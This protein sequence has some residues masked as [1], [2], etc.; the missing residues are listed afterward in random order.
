MVFER[1]R[2]EE[3]MKCP[4]CKSSIQT[5]WETD[6]YCPECGAKF[7]D[8]FK[9]QIRLNLDTPVEGMEGRAVPKGL[10]VDVQKGADGTMLHDLK[11]R[12]EEEYKNVLRGALSD[13]RINLNEIL[14]LARKK[15]ELN[16]D[17]KEAIRLQMEVAGE[18]GLTV[19]EESDPNVND[20]VMEIDENK[21]YWAGEGDFIDFRITNISD[22]L[23]DNVFVMGR[24]KHL[25]SDAKDDPKKLP[26][27]QNKIFH[28]R[29]MRLYSGIEVAHISV[30]YLDPKGNPSVYETEL[31]FRVIEKGMEKREGDKSINI[32]ITAEKIMGNDLSSLAEM[33]GRD[34][35]KEEGS[36][37][38]SFYNES[39]KVWR[40]LP[41]F[42]DEEKT[43]E[44]RNQIFIQKRFKEGED[45]YHK[46]LTLKERAY[47]FHSKDPKN[48]KK[49]L[50]NSV[51][52]LEAAKACFEKVLD[53]DPEHEGS[54][55]KAKDIEGVISELEKRIGVLR[56]REK[57]PSINLTSALLT[58]GN[59]QKYIYLYSKETIT[60]GRLSTNDMILRVL[61]CLPEE[62][63]PENYRK[64]LQISGLHA[65]IF[66][67][68]TG[69]VFI[70]DR[71]KENKG[72]KNGTFLDRKRLA[73]PLYGYPLTDK[74]K[75]DIAGALGLECNFIYNDKKGKT[76]RDR[77]DSC[78]TVLGSVSKS[79][80][81]IDVKG[82]VNAIKIVRTSN[83]S[84]GEEY[85]ILIRK[86]TIGRSLY[87][88]IIIDG[89]RVSD[90]H[91]Q[92]FY[93]DGH[94]W[95]EDLNSRH[96]TWVNAEKIESGREM[97]LGT[98]AEIVIGDIRMDFKGKE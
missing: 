31:E 40:R 97:P 28:L 94:Y 32:S 71:G 4:S 51:S 55:K 38:K 84:E 98:H 13:G 68:K 1:S 65:E 22:G 82:D 5:L 92:L 36:S 56:I 74:A 33:A 41:L 57:M 85:I 39:E 12:V 21:T 75:I 58:L 18:L 7:T 90:I 9:K 87:N 80:F 64:N 10:R 89:A 44:K 95:I 6:N 17:K 53:V 42:F 78:F 62:T 50:D 72:S 34:A 96:G 47:P 52:L 30:E 60:I 15:K 61:P 63:Y 81:G 27:Q 88:G 54:L 20:I 86:I 48:A 69:D 91:A 43:K 93:R 79:C 25:Q 16:L 83:F 14:V 67:S 2:L 23:L 24:F 70:R 19:D 29:F 35:Q 26:P 3:R 73:P 46:G 8:E 59:P 77:Q 49:I 11:I 76:E 66:L 37:K 45:N